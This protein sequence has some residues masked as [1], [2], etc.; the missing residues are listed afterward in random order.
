[1]SNLKAQQEKY[2]SSY[3]S[4][5]LG[6]FSEASRVLFHSS[7]GWLQYA[8]PESATPATSHIRMCIFP[9]S[10][11]PLIIIL[12]LVFTGRGLWSLTRGSCPA[13]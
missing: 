1:M 6:T 2:T 8:F 10:Y 13:R 5:E 12:Q 11:F 3:F 7:T 9:P 4:Q